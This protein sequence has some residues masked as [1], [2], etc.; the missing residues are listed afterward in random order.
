MKILDTEEIVE[1]LRH[2]LEARNYGGFVDL[3]SPDAVF[4]TPFGLQQNQ[5]QLKGTDAIRAHFDT[6]AQSASTKLLELHQVEAQL[7]PGKDQDTVTVEFHIKGK[8]VTSGESFDM[9]SSVAI[10]RC[11]HGQVTHYKD[12]PNN[13]GYAQIAGVLPQL[14]ASLIK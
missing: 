3:F 1:Q 14:A 5:K 9:P 12:F 6:I 11:A 2:F 13:I 10:I 4:E 7:H 8:S